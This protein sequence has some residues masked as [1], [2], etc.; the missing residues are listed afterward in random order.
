MIRW[1]PAVSHFTLLYPFKLASQLDAFAGA[2]ANNDTLNRA[3]TAWDPHDRP[4]GWVGRHLDN[5]AA[6]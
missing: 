2:P 1:L 3:H 5:L 6:G 4:G